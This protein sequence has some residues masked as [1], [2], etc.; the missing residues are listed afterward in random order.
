MSTT[1]TDLDLALKAKLFR[2]L[3]DRS[4]LSI[5][6][7]LREG[8]RAV[9]DIVEA[10]GL[11]QPN[12][13]NHLACLLDCGLVTR[14]ARGRYAIYALADG[15]VARLLALGEEILEDVADGMEGCSRFEGAGA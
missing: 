7:V 6:E 12:V 5:L 11:T 1:S 10:S 4:R 2:G 14:E 15:R 8:P 13:S 9:G 3:A